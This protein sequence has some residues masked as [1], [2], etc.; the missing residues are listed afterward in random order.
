MTRRRRRPRWTR[1]PRVDEHLFADLDDPE[2]AAEL[3]DPQTGRRQCKTCGC[4]GAPGDAR[5][6]QTTTT[7]AEPPKALPRAVAEQYAEFDRARTGERD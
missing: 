2:A 4:M 6:P 5:H 1:P 7:A 3:A